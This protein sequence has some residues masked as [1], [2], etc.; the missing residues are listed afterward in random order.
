MKK[1]Y[2]FSRSLGM[3]SGQISKGLGKNLQKQFDKNAINLDPISWSVISFLKKYNNST[4]QNIVQFLWIDKVKVKRVIDMLED[5]GFV[6]REIQKEDKRFNIVRLTD[7]GRSLFDRAVPYAE[8]VLTKAFKG[9][10]DSEEQQLIDLLIK[11]KGNLESDIDSL[12]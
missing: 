10:T 9:F 1:Q 5:A 4:Q 6:R 8:D 2:Q 11:V 7:K 3:L 12:S